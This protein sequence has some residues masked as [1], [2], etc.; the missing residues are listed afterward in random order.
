[1]RVSGTLSGAVLVAVVV[2]GCVLAWVKIRQLQ[3]EADRQEATAS[4]SLQRARDLEAATGKL[5][6]AAR[7]ARQAAQSWS[8]RMAQ[9]QA[10]LAEERET[11]EPLRQQI[12]RMMQQ[13]IVY[14]SQVERRDR[15]LK[16]NDEIVGNLRHDLEAARSLATA[17]AAR[18]R[19]LESEDKTRSESEANLRQSLGE[20]G[21]AL[22]TVQAERDRLLATERELTRKVEDL[23]RLAAEVRKSGDAAPETNAPVKAGP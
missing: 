6:Q 7:E 5:R 15:S 4:Q 11:H 23:T 10:Q 20:A 16:D 18:L 13:E 8:N 1:M 21:K 22:A 17:H 3:A 14:R 12:E 19:Q 2:V 9:A